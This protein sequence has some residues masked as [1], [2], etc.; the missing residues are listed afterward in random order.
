MPVQEQ[1]IL[2]SNDDLAEKRLKQ[3]TEQDLE[4]YDSWLQNREE[5]AGVLK[6]FFGTG[7][8]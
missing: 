1:R 7:Q 3:A 8:K 2:L 6:Q 4:N 5:H